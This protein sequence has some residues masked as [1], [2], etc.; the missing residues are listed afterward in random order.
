MLDRRRERAIVT[1]LEGSVDVDRHRTAL[2]ARY[3]DG[4][5]AILRAARPETTVSRAEPAGA[6]VLQ[7]LKGV[8][9]L[10][11]TGGNVRPELDELRRALSLFLEDILG[12]SL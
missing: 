1:L 10:C 11:E 8:S 5:V 7:M 9:R 3:R 4:L 6:V 12:S 2:R